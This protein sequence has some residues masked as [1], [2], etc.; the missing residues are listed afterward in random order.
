MTYLLLSILA[1]TIIFILFKTFSLYKVN[2]SQAIVTNYIVAALFGF[3]F[4]T[5]NISIPTLISQPWFIWS[6]ILGAV[7][8]SIFSLI[9]ITAQR[10]GISV[11]AVASKMSMI[12]PILFGIL[13]YKEH[14]NTL[15]ITGILIALIA[16]FLA[17]S[18][19]TSQTT[20]NTSSFIYPLLV[21]IGSGLIDTSIKFIDFHF[22][23]P[24]DASIF[25]A[26]IF[27]AAGILGIFLLLYNSI[28]KKESISFKNI[29]AG[30]SLGIPNYFSVYFLI[31]ALRH[32]L[33]DSSTV[34]T[35]NNVSILITSTLAGILIF[36]EQLLLK[37][38]I[39]IL[40]AILSIF[41]VSFS[42]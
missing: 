27:A 26:T 11:V 5:G 16:V 30:I 24:E 32:E 17:S 22:V 18:K 4:H 2:T 12:I 31:L 19:K 13:Y 14:T 10:N 7:F 29:I 25:P 40:L 3:F 28:I 39:G 20:T 8:I 9:A 34:F 15:K 21:F 38:W 1:T 6:L 41:L 37:N 42:F 35:I 23:K 33:M 36:R